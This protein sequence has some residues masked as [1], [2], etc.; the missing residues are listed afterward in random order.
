MSR[1]KFEFILSASS[2]GWQSVNKA[3]AGLNAFNREVG[4]GTKLMASARAQ[5]GALVGAYLG[6]N[7]LT[8]TVGIIKAADTASF[9]LESSLTAANREFSNI[10]SLET[11][12]QTIEQLS[13]DLRIYSKT[14]LNNAAAKTIDMTKRLGLSADQMQVVIARSA[15]LA[16]GKTDL[17]GAIERV[18]SA[19][20]GEAEASEYLGLTLNET[21]VKNWYEAAGA[22]E[23]AWKSLND[24]QKA[25]IRYQVFLEQAT[26][27][28][29]KA[30]D[31]VKTFAGAFDLVKAK[32]T[33]AITGNA[34]MTEVTRELATYL[35]QNADKLGDLAAT[36]A[37]AAV[38]SAKWVI[39][40]RELIATL[41]KWAI[42]LYLVTKPIGLLIT[43][44]NG[45]RAASLVM[46]GVSLISWLGKLRLVMLG[47][48]TVM[49]ANPMLAIAAGAISLGIKLKGLI[50][51]YYEMKQLNAEIKAQTDANAAANQQL[52]A[53]FRE[54][55]EAT[56]VTVTSMEEL[57]QAVKDGT[58]HFDDATGIWVKGYGKI[59][60]A[61]GEAAKEEKA[62]TKEKL[63]AMKAAYEKYVD[64][65]KTLQEQIVG[66]EKSLYE[67]LRDMARTGMS[68]VDAWNDLKKQAEEYKA[69]A[70]AAAESGDFSTAVEYADKAR[71]KYAELNKEVVENGKVVISAEE[72]RKTA[73]Q[74]VEETGKLGID[75]LKQQQDAAEKA[76]NALT[77][78]S[79][80]RDL[81]KSMDDAKR[82]WLK[83]WQDMRKQTLSELDAVEKRIDR[84]VKDR[85]VY[86]NVHT[87][88]KKATGG[89]VGV[90]GFAA[91][92]SPT[93]AW[94]MF[95]RLSSPL[96]TR[97]SGLRDDVPA[98]LKKWEFVQPPES[99]RYYGLRFMEMIRRRMLPKPMGFAVG[100]SPSGP[101]SLAG[102]GTGGTGLVINARF[103]FSGEMSQ[104]S[105]RNAREQ[106]RL[107]MAE[108][109]KM[110]RE[111]SR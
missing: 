96:I 32:I 16:A 50:D 44:F 68:D 45:L 109:Q 61:S 65:I 31:S 37:K 64:E 111:S 86:I 18:T 74:G 29:G 12:G 107:V 23:G 105:R 9:G 42:Q 98:M 14:D 79:N 41:G 82:T 102:A 88:E 57:D 35:E 24:L 77:E 104:P 46:T 90:R 47:V 101:V 8:N 78:Q 62:I 10:G 34:K 95:Q 80:W 53:R 4:S 6:F 75:A 87:V 70:I 48:N 51:R 103:N 84:I 58:L 89:L 39:E 28:Q 71:E 36:I 92:G 19:L 69:V 93:D 60:D 30:A 66:R 83:N 100:G 38:E 67:Q 5:V 108:M 76:M 7:A 13:K 11:W 54:I 56:G 22:T 1:K 63:D 21:Y 27:L 91:G 99:V 55:S 40:N 2:V 15:D 49:Y 110:H 97:G 43:L 59:A 25:Q 26:P 106:A 17:E 33:D 81:A 52:A 85:D 73:M 72:A 94:Q 20:R 3:R